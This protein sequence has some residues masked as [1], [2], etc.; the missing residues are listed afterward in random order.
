VTKSN[1]R[2]VAL[3]EPPR[4][5]HMQVHDTAQ[6]QA[7]ITVKQAAAIMNISE[8]GVYNARELMRTGRADLIDRVWAGKLSVRGALKLAKPE[9]YASKTEGEVRWDA[10][11]KAWNAV[12]EDQRAAFVAEILHQLQRDRFDDAG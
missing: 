11:V 10:L 2:A 7:R 6:V 3:R 1:G 12:T 4:P 5:A 9:K 8:R